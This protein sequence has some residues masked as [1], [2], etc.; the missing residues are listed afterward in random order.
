MSF[1]IVFRRFYFHVDKCDKL[2]FGHLEK[3]KK[4]EDHTTVRPGVS[5]GN[6]IHAL[7]HA[8]DHA[9]ERLFPG[10]QK[11]ME[12][13]GSVKIDSIK[14]LAWFHHGVW[15]RLLQNVNY[16]YGVKVQSYELDPSIYKVTGV[17]ISHDNKITTLEGD[18]VID[19]SGSISFSK[20]WMEKQGK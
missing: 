12:D 20:T 5:Q 9:M 17:N 4:P 10:F 18:I 19:T 13:R 6:H 3:D 2:L 16:K 8:G 11:D 7:L 14:D 15:K 1:I